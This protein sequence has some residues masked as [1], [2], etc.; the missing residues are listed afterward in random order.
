MGKMGSRGTRGQTLNRDGMLF[1]YAMFT[2]YVCYID[3]W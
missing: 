3:T 2:Y 1:M